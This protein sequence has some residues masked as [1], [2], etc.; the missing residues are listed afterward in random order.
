MKHK[1]L[2]IFSLMLAACGGSYED[3]A[4]EEAKAKAQK[5][6]IVEMTKE[7]EADLLKQAQGIFA[8]LPAIAENPAND[9]SAPKVE[10]GKTLYF[11]T[12]LSLTGNNSCN[13]CHNVATFGVDNEPTSIGD[14]GQRGGRNSPTTFNA[15]LHFLQFW[16][17]RAKDVE[18]QAGMPILNPVEMAIPNKEYLVNKLK[19]VD[20]YNQSFKAAFPQDADPL[21]YE[22]IAKAIAAFE[23]TLITP[24]RF[25]D[26][27]K[28]K[29]DALSAEEKH[30]LQTFIGAGCTSCHNGTAI[31]GAQIQKFGLINDYHALTGSS[32]ND[33][34]LQDQTKNEAD[35]DK[36]K[37]P[38]LRNIAQTFPYFH[39]GSVK[40]L[41]DAVRI[42]GKAQVN[43]DLS[44]DE[45]Q[46]IVTF[47]NAL[48]AD[49]PAEVKE[50]PKQ[51]TAQ[52]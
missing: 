44:Y 26:Y 22:N 3:V 27:L 9:C 32:T 8:A 47:L 13:S 5:M 39:D 40:N 41:A 25:D 46:S 36:F 19:G 14:A 24:S 49:I 50:A 48:T 7:Q 45:V 15:A 10:L 1:S 31:G 17:G 11:D 2:Y 21:T 4:R 29:A 28:G 20:L 38:S 43:K 30:G 34:G 37:V 35:K 51:L 6:G 33:K 16:D 52:K 23:R 42:M 12:R 18:E